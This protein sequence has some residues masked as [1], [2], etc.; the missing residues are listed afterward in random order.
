M[1]ITIW[2]RVYRREINRQQHGNN[3]EKAGNNWKLVLDI[4]P[5]CCI[6]VAVHRTTYIERMTMAVEWKKK[7]ADFDALKMPSSEWYRYRDIVGAHGVA[8]DMTQQLHEMADIMVSCPIKQSFRAYYMTKYIT[9]M[10]EPYEYEVSRCCAVGALYIYNEDAPVHADEGYA[11]PRTKAVLKYPVLAN[12]VVSPDV[13]NVTT[14]VEQIIYWNDTMGYSFAEIAARLR[15]Y[16]SDPLLYLEP[17][18]W[19]G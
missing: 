7:Y 16:A 13:P 2:K 11:D 1:D 9:D 19:E 10:S 3:L 12:R 15:E 4:L 8:K 5:H 18:E 6:M 14:L 17:G